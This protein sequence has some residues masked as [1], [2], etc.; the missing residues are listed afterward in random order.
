MVF[1][2]A[3]YLLF[4][5]IFLVTLYFHYFGSNTSL[6]GI[7]RSIPEFSKHLTAPT[8]SGY[9]T[10]GYFVNWV[11]ASCLLPIYISFT[12]DWQAIYGRNY[13]PQDLPAEKLTHI[14]YAFANVRPETGEV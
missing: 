4:T 5:P 6:F 14:L 8:M 3:L 11:R 1:S 9:K 12:N 13:N 7:Q 10:V 2:R